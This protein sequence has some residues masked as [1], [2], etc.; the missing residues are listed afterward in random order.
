MSQP[1]ERADDW[2][3]VGK[4]V[5]QFDFS[6]ALFNRN[7]REL[8]LF[9]AHMS[10]LREALEIVGTENGWLRHEAT[11]EVLFLLHN[12]LAAAKSLIDHARVLYEQFYQPK[13][14]IAGYQKQ[15]D[16]RFNKHPLS[17]FVQELRN[18][19]LHVRLPSVA[20]EHRFE[21]GTLT[22]HVTLSRDELLPS[23]EWSKYAEQ[24]LATA[25]PTIDIATMIR[26][27]HEHVMAFYQWF[28]E[29]QGEVHDSGRNLYADMAQGR[30]FMPSDKMLA[31]IAEGVTLMETSTTPP[32]YGALLKVLTPALTI[33]D[34]QLLN[35]CSH[36]PTLWLE[37]ALASVSTRLVVPDELRARL[38]AL[39]A[40]RK[41]D[42]NTVGRQ[43]A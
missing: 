7:Y 14:L 28:G 11:R 15:I 17:R 34:A 21:H 33:A 39:I 22:I 19:S 5:L 27:Y 40:P 32:T 10:D 6:L 8:R 26:D 9:L 23:T 4:R 16:N 37:E 43:D 36:D 42:T 30:L 25:G 12:F 13:G 29:R 20:L 38:F 24:F 41:G 18:Q 2:Q 31:E 1:P 35:L 3:A